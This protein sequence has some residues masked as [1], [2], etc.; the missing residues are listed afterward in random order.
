MPVAPDASKD[1]T[2]S[3]NVNWAE[4]DWTIIS[5]DGIYFKAPSKVFW[6]LSVSGAVGS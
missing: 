2:I 6:M 3:Y 4:G 5:S 1:K